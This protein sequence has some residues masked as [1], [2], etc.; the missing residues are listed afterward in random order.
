M[1]DQY[2]SVTRI[3]SAT[4]PQEDIDALERWRKR[5]GYAE[6]EKISNAALQRGKMYDNFVEDYTNGIDIPH[7]QLKEYL[8]QFEIVSREQT[9]YSNEYGY[10][11]RYDCIFAKNGILILNDFKGSGRKKSREYLKDYPLQIAA[12]IK[13]IEEIGVVINWGMISVILS[14]QIQTFVFDHCEIEKYFQEF[15]IRLK[16]Y[17]NAKNA[18]F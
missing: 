7:P 6:A 13:A 16:K 15:I 18:D 8:S 12:Y 17:N 4:K 3:L 2:P 10:K 1:S 9:I 5:I 11:G 14:D